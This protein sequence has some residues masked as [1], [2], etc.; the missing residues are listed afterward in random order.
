MFIKN[1]HRPLRHFHQPLAQRHPR[2][3]RI[4]QTSSIGSTKGL[5]CC[6]RATGMVEDEEKV[7]LENKF[8]LGNS[9]RR[10][11]WGPI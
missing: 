5:E 8:V 9:R 11:G 4:T 10:S 7:E 6:K 1:T 2:A 3:S